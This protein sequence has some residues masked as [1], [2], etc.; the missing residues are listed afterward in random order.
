[1]NAVF[2]FLH[3]MQFTAYGLDKKGA[4]GQNRSAL[5][6]VDQLTLERELGSQTQ[7]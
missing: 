4:E 2:N 1:L 3:E 6:L 7:C 5:C